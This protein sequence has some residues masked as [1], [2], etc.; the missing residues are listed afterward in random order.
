MRPSV[1]YTHLDVY[2]R[3][4]Y[5]CIEAGHPV[6]D[7]NSFKCTQAAL[8]LVKGLNQKDTVLFLLSGGGSALFE[9]PVISG[10]ELADLTEQLLASGADIV[11]INTFRK[12]MSR[13]KGCLLYTSNTIDRI[14]LFTKLFCF[15]N[16]FHFSVLLFL[17]WL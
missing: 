4:A 7:E 10:K 16:V 11:E 15:N 13:V 5:T 2:K 1:S 3:Q 6:P 8:E 12:R 14:I 9:D 17:S